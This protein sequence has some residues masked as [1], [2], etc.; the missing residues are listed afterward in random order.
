MYFRLTSL[1]YELVQQAGFACSSI[2]NYQELKQEIC[3]G[4]TKCYVTLD[5]TKRCT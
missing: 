4:K 1:L 3:R 2:P 5:V